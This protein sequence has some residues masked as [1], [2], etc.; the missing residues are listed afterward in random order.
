[1]AHIAGKELKGP[2]HDTTMS[3]VK[4]NSY[5][6]LILLCP[7]CH[8]KIDKQVNTYTVEKLHA[9]K[10]DH[11]VWVEKMLKRVTPDVGFAELEVVVCYIT[12]GQAVDNTSYDL[13]TVK[14]KIRRNSLSEQVEGMIKI[15][16][17]RSKEV[18][19]YLDAHPDAH[20]GS[21]LSAGFVA[22]YCQKRDLGISGDA[23]FLSL[24]DYAAGRSAD[25]MRRVAGMVVLVYLFE[26]CEVFER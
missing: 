8:K 5:D 13:I 10:H 25:F 12:S 23:L 16:L 3:D 4:K 24:V 22:E 21:R 1:M 19:S 18:K 11:L 2:R 15:G 20:F 14:D 6:N 26:A 9:I 7:T 17:S